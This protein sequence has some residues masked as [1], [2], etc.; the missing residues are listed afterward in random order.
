MG[1]HRGQTQI[2]CVWPHMRRHVVILMCYNWTKK[3]DK[4][5]GTVMVGLRCNSGAP[6]MPLE[7]PSALLKTDRMWEE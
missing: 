1:A 3:E 4:L 5:S 7:R 2:A 6:R